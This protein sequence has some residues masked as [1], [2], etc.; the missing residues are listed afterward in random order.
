MILRSAEADRNFRVLSSASA[1]RRR[2]FGILP[3]SSKS[4]NTPE[5]SFRRFPRRENRHN[6]TMH[7]RARKRRKPSL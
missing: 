7:Q 6:P 5:R 2:F 3:C 1:I 4:V